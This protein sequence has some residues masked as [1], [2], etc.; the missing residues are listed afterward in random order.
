MIFSKQKKSTVL[1]IIHK[2]GN[3][4]YVFIKK[5]F[6]NMLQKN[7]ML[8]ILSKKKLRRL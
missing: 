1:W 5:Q 4:M 7:I 6:V 8:S 3:V 2:Y